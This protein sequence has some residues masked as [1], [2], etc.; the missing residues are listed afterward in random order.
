L[1]QASSLGLT[2]PHL[3]GLLSSVRGGLR[4]VGAIVSDA[5]PEFCR[6]SQGRWVKEA[7]LPFNPW[8]NQPISEE[9]QPWGVAFK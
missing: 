3:L 4:N 9:A 8:T 5:P 7:K 1:R 6:E 2:Q